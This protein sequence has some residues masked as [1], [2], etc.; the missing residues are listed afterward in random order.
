MPPKAA[1]KQAA[2]AAF[3]IRRHILHGGHRVAIADDP[4]PPGF[5]CTMCNKFFVNKG[6]YATHCRY[7]HPES[8]PSP[9]AGPVAMEEES[10]R[11]VAPEG[12]GVERSVNEG[13]DTSAALELAEV[14]IGEGEGARSEVEVPEDDGMV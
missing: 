11:H 5:E 1:P 7:T 10:S 3:D 9:G 12:H 14:D 6:A 8:A 2:L 13:D 4:R